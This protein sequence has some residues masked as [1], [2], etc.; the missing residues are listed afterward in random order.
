MTPAYDALVA[1]AERE[2][3]H[4][5]EGRFDELEQIGADRRA[6]LAHLPAQAPATA[7]PALERAAALQARTTVALEAAKARAGG[8]LRSLGRGRDATRAYGRA[9]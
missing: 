2:H 5:A 6:L 1:L 7:L 8:E 4:V 9:A 3:A